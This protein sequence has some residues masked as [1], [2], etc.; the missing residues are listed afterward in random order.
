MIV[1]VTIVGM[2]KAPCGRRNFDL[3]LPPG[4]TVRELLQKTGFADHHIPHIVSSVRGQ[5]ARLNTPLENGLTV[6]LSILIGGG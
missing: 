1:H 3:E 6:E 4:A 2:L 5:V